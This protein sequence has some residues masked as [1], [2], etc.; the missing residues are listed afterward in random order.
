MCRFYI[1]PAVGDSHF[2]SASPA[3]CADVAAKFPNFVYES[4]NVM[5]V[6]LPEA[7]TGAC[8]AG[9]SPVYRMWNTRADSNHRYT[10]DT[11]VRDAMLA[12]GYVA[13]GYGPAGVAMC[14]ASAAPTFELTLTAASVLLLPGETRD[15]YATVTPRNGFSGTVALTASGL[16]GECRRAAFA[17]QRHR[18][19]RRGVGG[20]AP[21]GVRAAPPTA[22]PGEVTVSASDGGGNDIRA[23]FSLGVATAGDPVAVRLSAIASVEERARQLSGQGVSGLPLVQAVAAFMATR[24]EYMATGVD[25]ETLSAWGRFADGVMHVVADNREPPSP[26]SGVAPGALT[27]KSGAEVPGETTARLLH[28]FKSR[29]QLR[30]HA[31]RRDARLPGGQGLERARGRGGTGRASP[32]SGARAATASSSSTRTARA[33]RWAIRPSPT[34]RCTRSSRRRWWTKVAK[35]CSRRT[36]RRCK[37]LHFTAANGEQV[38][39]FL[40]LT[41]ARSST[42][43]M[44]SP[45]ASLQAY[46]SF[47]TNSVVLINACYSGVNRKFIDAVP[48][49]RRRRLP[50]M[51]VIAFAGGRVPGG[52]LFRR[53]HAGRQPARRQG[54]A[55]AAGLSRTTSC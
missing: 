51:V 6:G 5:Q 39:G 49:R 30:S 23:A 17:G 8:R 54:V 32:R 45:T 3:E 47:A 16:P 20:P 38:E 9:W 36:L 43:D 13:E 15:V 14:A 21:V 48:A 4:P 27:V 35:R 10:T 1:P 12:K 50:R 2:Y 29:R 42:R 26:A 41:P 44:R 53:P 7:A 46:M 22:A 40:G 28:S 25:E 55:A 11:S 37:L 31:D 18:G 33:S 19:G 34:A 24:P 52:A